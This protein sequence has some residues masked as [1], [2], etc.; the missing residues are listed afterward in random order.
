MD[1]QTI[2]K[3]D[4]VQFKCEVQKAVRKLFYAELH[5]KKLTHIKVKD[6]QYFGQRLPQAYLTTVLTTKCAAFC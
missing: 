4:M 3:I 5:K 1:E 2:A 6:I